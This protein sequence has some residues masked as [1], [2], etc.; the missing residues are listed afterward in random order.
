MRKPGICPHCDIQINPR[1]LL[2]VSRRVPYICPACGGESVIP[3]RSGMTSVLVFVAALGMLLIMLDFLGAPRVAIFAAA[4]I[5]VFAIPLVF[6][7]ISRFEPEIPLQAARS[8]HD[9]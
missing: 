3:P 4:L 1:R 8:N 5:A 7:R 6:A 9:A 2:R